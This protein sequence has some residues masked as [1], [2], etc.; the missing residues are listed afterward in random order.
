ML[1]PQAANG[2][3]KIEFK[4]NGASAAEAPAVQLKPDAEVPAAKPVA[5]QPVAGLTEVDKR[6]Q[7]AERFGVPVAETDKLKTRAERQAAVK[8]QA[9]SLVCGNLSQKRWE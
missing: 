6:K 5:A 3:M 4:P 9:A 8:L 7:R 2:R 1:Q